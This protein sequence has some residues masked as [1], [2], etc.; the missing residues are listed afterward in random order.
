M[1]LQRLTE[2]FQEPMRHTFLALIVLGLGASV[3]SNAYAELPDGPGK[4]VTV[5]VCG[6]CHS[7]D[8]AASLHQ[9]EDGW[10]DTIAKMVKMG[11]QGSDDEFNTI[12]AYLTKNFGPEEAPHVNINKADSVELESSLVLTKS[13][14]AA[15]IHYRDEKGAF[16]SIEDLRNI[17]GLDFKKIETQKS[18]ITF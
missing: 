5:R 12:L 11:A 2:T 7:A 15:V 10:T 4:A 14:A 3:A 9:D 16:K 6:K 1:L 17:A 8:K 18:R 13:E